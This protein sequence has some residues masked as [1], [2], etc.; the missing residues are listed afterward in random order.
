MTFLF[1][2][3]KHRRGVIFKRQAWSAS[4]PASSSLSSTTNS[5]LNSDQR[6]PQPG[7][8]I[9]E[10]S[11]AGD[12]SGEERFYVERDS[13]TPITMSAT[14]ARATMIPDLFTTPPPL[15]DLLNTQTS[16]T[17]EET[18]Q[19]CLPFLTGTKRWIAYNDHGIPPLDRKRHIAFLHKS[20][21]KLPAPYVTADASR[22]WMF[23]WALTGLSTMGEDVSGYRER[24]IATIRPIQNITGGFGG[25]HGQMSHLAPTYAIVLSL[26]IVGGREAL[27]LIDRKAMWKWLGE[28]KQPGGGFQMSVGGEEDIRYVLVMHERSQCADWK[29]R[30]IYCCCF[31][32]SP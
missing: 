19:E 4:D 5:L 31:N 30:S 26:S 27:D 11:Q 28:L 1:R 17:Q 2:G 16:Q 32:H 3:R 23:Y 15:R 13:R 9:E 8:T 22:P 12:A 10:S 29:K 24:V 21:G 6:T 20:L 14:T 25:G 7:F 18:I